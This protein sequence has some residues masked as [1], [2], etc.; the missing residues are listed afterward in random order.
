M[1]RTILLIA[2]I[3]AITFLTTS[4][5]KTRVCKCTSVINP[6]ENYNTTY[7]ATYGKT[8]A[9]ADCENLQ[10]SGRI[11]TPDYTCTLE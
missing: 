6:T 5:F 9:A 11:S 4:C 2:G 10:T 3:I 7:D 8:K 1:K